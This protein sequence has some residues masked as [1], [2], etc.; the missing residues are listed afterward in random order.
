MGFFATSSSLILPERTADCF[1]IS[2]SASL[3]AA[4]FCTA[5]VKFL[6]SFVCSAF[7]M[8]AFARLKLVCESVYASASFFSRSRMERFASRSPSTI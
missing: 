6:L 3:A 4:C 7:A 1:A 8:E 5:S 2:S